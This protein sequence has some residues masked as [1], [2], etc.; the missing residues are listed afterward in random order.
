MSWDDL[1]NLDLDEILSV[2]P[3]SEPEP[4]VVKELGETELS[5]AKT[6]VASGLKQSAGQ[7]SNVSEVTEAADLL[8]NCSI[9]EDHKAILVKLRD[10]LPFLVSTIKL[11]IETEEENIKNWNQGKL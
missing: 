7:I 11:A 1:F 9:F 6:V 8:I 3:T 5:A 10:Q 4:E 2:A